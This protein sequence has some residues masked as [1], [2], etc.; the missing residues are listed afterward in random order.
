MGEDRVLRS[1][2]SSGDPNGK[3]VFSLN[4]VMEKLASIE[5]MVADTNTNLKKTNDKLAELQ[6]SHNKLGDE[7]TQ[8]KT[9]LKEREAAVDQRL[10]QIDAK[11]AK[12]LQ[13]AENSVL[14]AELN[15][16]RY[17]IVVEGIPKSDLNES[18]DDCVALA[19]DF[20]K[21][22]LGIRK[23][24]DIAICHA[25]RL[26]VSSKY[27]GSRPPPLIFKIIK[28]LDKKIIADHLRNLKE[29]NKYLANDRKIFVKLNHLPSLLQKDEVSLKTL[30]NDARLAKKKPKFKFHRETGEYR[31]HVGQKVHRPVREVSSVEP[32]PSVMTCWNKN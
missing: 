31:L 3:K 6:S 12:A 26:A 1:T 22:T 11:Y 15:S 29:V 4:D 19:K 28:L 23:A 17:N 7:M 5:G 9:H 25:H 8:L 32:L 27:Q 18:W 21:D 30:F 10:D 13:K 16:K 2:S 20:L 14:A 24:D